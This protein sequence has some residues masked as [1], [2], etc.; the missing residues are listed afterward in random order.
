MAS[1]EYANV[2]YVSIV[3]MLSVSDVKEPTLGFNFLKYQVQPSQNRQNRFHNRFISIRNRF[4]IVK[5]ITVLTSFVRF[6]PYF[7]LRVNVERLTII[8]ILKHGS[9]GVRI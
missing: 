4:V 7:P 3:C 1:S 6:L 2:T 8:S 9:R 5:P